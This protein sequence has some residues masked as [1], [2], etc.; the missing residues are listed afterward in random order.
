M[1]KTW[2]MGIM[3]T[4]LFHPSWK[5]C[6]PTTSTLWRTKS[7]TTTNTPA[8][9]PRTA[10][11]SAFTTSISSM[12]IKATTITTISATTSL[13]IFV[14][15]S[16]NK[17]GISTIEFVIRVIF[18]T[19]VIVPGEI[20]QSQVESKCNDCTPPPSHNAMCSTNK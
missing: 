1:A 17:L 19:I 5:A 10:T 13:A 8:T 3:T 6:F 12:T 20:N 2:N 4:D 9:T 14:C 18:L 11:T 16:A 7:I 15:A